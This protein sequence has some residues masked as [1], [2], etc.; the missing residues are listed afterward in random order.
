L[1][2]TLAIVRARFRNGRWVIDGTT[3]FFGP[4]AIGASVSCSWDRCAAGVIPCTPTNVPIGSG[5]VDAFGA[6]LVDV[7]GVSV[8]PTQ[9]T[10]QSVT[11]RS[12]FG[13]SITTTN[14]R[15]R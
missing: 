5:T 10:L 14:V 8:S 11:C 2:E 13:A 6:W 4:T 7:G 1:Q 12:T 15:F 3:T 9:T